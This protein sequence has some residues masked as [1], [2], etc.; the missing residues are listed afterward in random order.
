MMYNCRYLTKPT[1]AIKYLQQNQFAYISNWTLSKKLLY[2]C[3]QQHNGISK[4]YLKTSCLKNFSFIA[5]VVETGDFT[6]EYLC[7][8]L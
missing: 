5:G 7:E 3:K 1:P 6:L 2:E 4:K 8:F